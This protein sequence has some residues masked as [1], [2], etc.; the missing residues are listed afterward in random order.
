V[1]DHRRNADIRRVGIAC[2]RIDD[3]IYDT[4]AD[5]ESEWT[6]LEP[7]FRYDCSFSRQ[8]MSCDYAE[9]IWMRDEEGV[10]CL[11]LD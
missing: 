10:V 1:H 7:Y 4:L 8:I 9:F 6:E 3:F 11:R 2:L 5:M